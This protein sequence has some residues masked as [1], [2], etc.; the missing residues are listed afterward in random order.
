M[1]THWQHLPDL[2]G[3]SQ[4]VAICQRGYEEKPEGPLNAV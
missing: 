4:G 3:L 1:L 2:D